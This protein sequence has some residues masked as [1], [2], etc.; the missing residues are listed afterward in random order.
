MNY[1]VRIIDLGKAF[2]NAHE[3]VLKNCGPMLRSRRNAAQAW[4]EM[5]GVTPVPAESDGHWHWVDFQD[6]EHYLMFVLKWS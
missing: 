2:V 6:R 1:T 4:T 5:L 3:Y